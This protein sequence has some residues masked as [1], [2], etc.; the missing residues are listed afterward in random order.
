[1]RQVV[2]TVDERSIVNG[3]KI[4]L[5][6]EETPSYVLKDGE[7]DLTDLYDGDITDIKGKFYDHVNQ[8]FSDAPLNPIINA[9]VTSDNDSDH[10]LMNGMLPLKPNE[11][12]IKEGDSIQADIKVTDFLDNPI[13]LT[14]QAF[15]MPIVSANG[16]ERLIL[17]RFNGNSAFKSIKFPMS[18]VYRVTQEMIN[19]D[20]PEGV[21]EFIFD[22]ITIYVHEDDLLYT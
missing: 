20:L 22:D 6:D 13:D 18:G 17:I 14:G 19:R 16:S 15:S 4:I 12:Y 1:M 7:I 11:L 5:S 9:S 10:P 2:I 8:T 21:P 3:G